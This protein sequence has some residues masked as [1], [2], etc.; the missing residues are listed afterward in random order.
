MRTS[1]DKSKNEETTQRDCS[2]KGGVAGAIVGA[3]IAGVPG[4]IVGGIGGAIV[5]LLN[6][7]GEGKKI[8]KTC[9]L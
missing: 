1:K 7:D 6:C 9:N 4:A 5:S 2:L 3:E 8:E